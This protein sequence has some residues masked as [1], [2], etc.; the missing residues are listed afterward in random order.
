MTSRACILIVLRKRC[1][2]VEEKKLQKNSTKLQKTRRTM[3][4]ERT[5]REAS[6]ESLELRTTTNALHKIVEMAFRVCEAV[7]EFFF[8]FFF[9]LANLRNLGDFLFPE[10]EGINNF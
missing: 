1:T 7:S 2:R 5:L 6:Q 4:D 9:F 8:F 10:N 3:N